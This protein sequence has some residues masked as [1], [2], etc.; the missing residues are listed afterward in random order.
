MEIPYVTTEQLR[1]LNSQKLK[2]YKQQYSTEAG[3]ITFDNVVKLNI[4]RELIDTKTTH[5][6][7]ADRILVQ[8]P[9]TELNKQL[10][11]TDSW[12]SAKYPVQSDSDATVARTPPA[13]FNKIDV[14]LS[15]AIARWAIRDSAKIEGAWDWNQRMTVREVGRK[16][17]AIRDEHAL[18]NLKTGVPS[19]NKI[20]ASNKWSENAA[21]IEGDIAEAVGKIVDN[22]D[23]DT[24]ELENNQVFAVVLP[25]KIWHTIQKLQLIRNINDT[26]KRFTE[27]EFSVR[28]FF[29]RKPRNDP[30][31]STWPIES[32]ALVVPMQNPD[33][34]AIATLSGSPHIARQK[35]METPTGQEVFERRWFKHYV[36][37]Q[38]FDGSTTTNALLAQIDTVA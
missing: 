38:P 12:V 11:A 20:T 31:F 32:Q 36:I 15:L 29:S 4:T 23:I 5:L 33:I 1:S 28:F 18:S 30:E 24:A 2:E 19:G 8:D 6:A 34:G 7:V 21:D 26:I 27:Q 13:D 9:M 25:A 17:A 14:S 37:P 22:S 3:E 16:L 10:F 35:V